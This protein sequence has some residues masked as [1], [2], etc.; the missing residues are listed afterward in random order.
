MAKYRI[1]IESPDHPQQILDC[2]GYFVGAFNGEIG[3]ERQMEVGVHGIC[4]DDLQA[5]LRNA[6]PFRKNVAA[7]AGD[8]ISCLI[9]AV[10]EPGDEIKAEERNAEPVKEAEEDAAE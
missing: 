2:D 7:V 3:G 6:A 5:V 1:T 9:E 10:L 8:A 4:D